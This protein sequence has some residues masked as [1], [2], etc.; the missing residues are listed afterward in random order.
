MKKPFLFFTIPLI[1]GILYY[2]Y[3]DINILFI[4]FLLI[5][6]LIIFILS[7]LSKKNNI[8]IIITMFFIL[9]ILVAHVNMENSILYSFIDENVIV[10]GLV[11]KEKDGKDG[12]SK[13]VVLTN[14]VTLDNTKYR[15]EEKLLLTLIGENK[16][17]VGEKIIFR[18]ILNEPRENTNP[19]LFNYKFYLL[20]NKIYT[21]ST[22]KDYSILKTEMSNLPWYMTWK[23]KFIGKVENT[24]N[25]YLSSDNS[26]IMKSIIL[27]DYSYLD[28]NVLEKYRDLGL[29][30]LMATSGLH[31]GIISIFLISV[32]SFLGIDR[33]LSYIITILLIWIFGYFVDFPPSVLRSNIM[34]TLLFY[35]KALA[36]RYDPVNTLFFSIF[37]ILIIN[38][39]WLFDIG[40][41]LSFIVTFSIVLFTPAI[42]KMF[43]PYEGSILN[44]LYGI[45]A[46][47]IGSLPI[48]SYYFNKISIL[49]IIANLIIVPILSLCLILAFLLIPISLVSEVFARS[50]SL[51]LNFLLSSQNILISLLY[52]GPMVTI[53]VASPNII[54]ILLF[55]ILILLTLGII[56]L[57]KLDKDINKILFLCLTIIIMSTSL[58]NFLDNTLTVNF[59]DVG[60]GDCIVVEYRDKVFLIDTGGSFFKDYSIGKNIVLPYLTKKGIF[61]VDG[62]FISHFHLDHCESLIYLM[63]HL[64]ID[65]IFIS[66]EDENNPLYKQIITKGY[67]KNIPIIKLQT[68]D[69]YYIHKDIYFEF[70]S[71]DDTILKREVLDDNNKSMV[72]VLNIMERKVLFTGDIEKEVEKYISSK[73]NFE[74][75]FLKV[76]H[77]GSNTSSTPVFIDTIR[78]KYGFIQVGKNNFGHPSEEVLKEYR[79]RGIL[80]YRNDLHGHISLSI[81]KNN[82]LIEPYIRDKFSIMEWIVING[83]IISL[84]ILYSIIL[85]IMVKK[86][87][88]IMERLKTIDL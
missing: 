68:G 57:Q 77:H 3:I 58:I 59:V 67:N 30:H 88:V 19:K 6:I 20:T 47:Q 2:S 44:S 32:L 75:D 41:Q 62:I 51:I 61:K 43:Y 16:L 50:L 5:S 22:I 53:K 8:I 45:L 73:I 69:R 24:F 34:F 86:Y 18:G 76:P 49:S 25:N 63:D 1:I 11:V 10:E 13:Y 35:S 29:S 36:K 66:Y 60:Q 64:T 54:G 26:L 85:Y 46:A 70:I 15:V 56:N 27:G 9:G 83:Y 40:F 12:L 7:I 79:D 42:K 82:Y 84:N 38:P 14:S 17:K 23:S 81:D 37:I 74:I 48:I 55:Y 52:K 71:P 28:D 65:H 21:I 80:I 87:T 31:I 39:F 33:R 78:P 4:L 72:L